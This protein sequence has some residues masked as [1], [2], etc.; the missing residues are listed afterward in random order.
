MFYKSGIYDKWKA[1]G[2]EYVQVILIDNPLAAPYDSNQIG[3][4]FKTR[5]EI[6]VKAVKK[7]HFFVYARTCKQYLRVAYVYAHLRVHV[8]IICVYTHT[9]IYTHIYAYIRI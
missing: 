4:Q 2:I 3:T 7:K 8:T 9:R 5:S 1:L 6:S